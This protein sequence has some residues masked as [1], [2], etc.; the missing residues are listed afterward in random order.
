MPIHRLLIVPALVLVAFT[1]VAGSLAEAREGEHGRGPERERH[2]DEHHWIEPER[3]WDGRPGWGWHGLD[4]DRWHG[5]RWFHGEHLG[6]L[7]RWWIVDG[8]WHS[9]PAPTYPYP[10]P[11]VPPAVVAPSASSWYYCPSANAYYP[12]VSECPEGWTPVAPQSPR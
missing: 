2:W 4:A 5:G 11:Y 8:A 7:G 12:Y 10:D 6:R 1:T 9:Y 3:H